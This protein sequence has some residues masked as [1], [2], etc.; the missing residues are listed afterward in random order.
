MSEITNSTSANKPSKSESAFYLKAALIIISGCLLCEVFVFNARHFITHWGDGQ[1]DIDSPECGIANMTFNK[2]YGLFIPTGEERSEIAFLDVNKRIVTVY[3]DALFID[4][5]KA[6]IQSFFISYYGSD[7]HLI[8]TTSQ[9]NVIRGVEESK[10]VTLHASGK[11]SNIRILYGEQD[12]VVF[13]RNVT[14]NKP[15]PLK[16]FWPRLLLFSITAFCIVIIKH[17]KLFS[18]P[19]RN[20]SLR[21]NILTA[22]IIAV[23]IAYHFALMLFSEPFYRSRPFK[24]NFA[25]V[26]DQYNAEIVDAILDGHA[27]LNIEPTEELK[28]LKN[29]YDAGEREN[30]NVIAP[31]DHAYYNGKFYSYFGIVQVLI[32]SLPYKLITGHYIPTRIAVFIFSALA[33]VFLILVWDRLV[34]KYMR[35][36]RLGMYTLGR[37]TVAMCSMITFLTI[38]PYIYEVAVSAALFLTAL[39]FWLI[40]GNSAGKK[41]SVRRAA[42]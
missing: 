1:I 11:I 35:K 42:I 13:I 17:K 30:A 21:Q 10:Y 2:Q 6:R 9:I 39:G 32:L 40:L 12:P 41:A 25:N 7:E 3:I 36:M 34:F 29:P 16:I 37:L 38:R 33:C 15:I 5:E 20:G 14:L 24:E 4:D 8:R 28:A 23:F 19:L 18:L 31:G 27:Y 22:G 26:L